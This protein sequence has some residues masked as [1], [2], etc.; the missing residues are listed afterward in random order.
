MDLGLARL[1]LGFGAM[2]AWGSR[3]AG[4]GI[5]GTMLRSQRDKGQEEPVLKKAKR[6]DAYLAARPFY[7]PRIAFRNPVYFLLSHAYVICVVP[8]LSNAP[9]SHRPY[10]VRRQTFWQ[11]PP[12]GNALL[13]DIF[14]SVTRQCCP[15]MQIFSSLDQ[16]GQMCSAECKSARRTTTAPAHFLCLSPVA[17]MT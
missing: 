1:P 5:D 17:R 13:V 4:F 12:F 3:R 11:R 8:R 10:G 15:A 14:G 9:S 6:R 7:H 2:L 16:I